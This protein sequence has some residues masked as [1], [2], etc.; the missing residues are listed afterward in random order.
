MSYEFSGTQGGPLLE[1]SSYFLLQMLLTS[2]EFADVLEGQWTG[3][4]SGVAQ[5]KLMKDAVV[6]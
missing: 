3:M 1:A 4:P 5:G 2:D 6:T